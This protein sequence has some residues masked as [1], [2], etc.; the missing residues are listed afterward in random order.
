[1]RTGRPRRLYGRGID[2]QAQPPR[3]G[4][5][6]PTPEEDMPMQGDRRHTLGSSDAA[7][8]VGRDPWRTP[9]DVWLEK[10]GRLADEGMPSPAMEAGTFLEAGIL[11]WAAG[12]LGVPITR[13]QVRL[14]HPVYPELAATLDGVAD[15]GTII[16]AK[17]AGLVGTGTGLEEWGDAHTDAVPTHVLLQAHH[18]FFVAGAQADWAAGGPRVCC[19]PALL[20][21]RGLV[22]FQIERSDALVTALVEAERRFWQDYVLQDVAPPDSLPSLE[23]LKR[24]GREPAATVAIPPETVL[25]WR[26]AR[27]QLEEATRAE[28]TTRRVLLTALGTAEAGTCAL[29]TLTYRAHE[30]K[31]YHVKATTYRRLV[32]TPAKTTEGGAL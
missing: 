10:T 2:L 5:P 4:D 13:R 32:W 11:D 17:T 14:V 18:Q 21:R 27:L 19:V 16:E 1:M 3:A 30:K 31:S 29:G 8:V 20:A 6:A 7:A 26:G 23:V 12:A 9:A 24:I 28:E 25:A 15:D 22:L